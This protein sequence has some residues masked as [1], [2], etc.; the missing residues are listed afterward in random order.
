MEAVTRGETA[1]RAV[2]PL[3]IEGVVGAVE[4]AEGVRRDAGVALAGAAVAIVGEERVCE[5]RQAD[6]G[7]PALGRARERRAEDGEEVVAKAYACAAVL[8][9]ST[10]R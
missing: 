2:A 3:A 10:S 7:G 8:D 6:L 5:D 4:L 9:G 1:E